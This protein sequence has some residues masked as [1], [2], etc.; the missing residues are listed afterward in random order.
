MPAF[1]PA[2]T[3]SPTTS[4]RCPSGAGRGDWRSGW[5]EAMPGELPMMQIVVGLTSFWPTDAPQQGCKAQDQF[6][7]DRSAW[8]IVCDDG[9][10]EGFVVLGVLENLDDGFSGQTMADSVAARLAL[11]LVRAR[12]S[13][14]A[15]VLSVGLELSQEVMDA[16]RSGTTG[17]QH[18]VR[19]RK[20]GRR[21]ARSAPPQRHPPL[22]R[23]I[24]RRPFEKIELFG[25]VLPITQ[26]KIAHLCAYNLLGR[27]LRGEPPAIIAY[28]V[29]R[30]GAGRRYTC[31]TQGL[32][33]VS[34]GSGREG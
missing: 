29:G 25:F 11:A 26:L 13:A 7:L 31:H 2:R 23:Q 14:C 9:C 18:S 22:P 12:T 27:K 24:L 10:L 19:A 28:D 6:A 8:V 5:P 17:P 4:I 20:G 15:G 32:D 33:V 21:T 1:A 30:R 3:G 16:R 34:P